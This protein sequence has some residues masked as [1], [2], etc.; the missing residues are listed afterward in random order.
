MNLS[1][2]CWFIIFSALVL[3]AAPRWKVGYLRISF[4]NLRFYAHF[5]TTDK[6][7]TTW[8]SVF[9][10]RQGTR[11]GDKYWHLGEL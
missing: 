1:A 8:Y 5:N 2:F 3:H 11:S 4:Q 9:S 10:G 6:L 7:V